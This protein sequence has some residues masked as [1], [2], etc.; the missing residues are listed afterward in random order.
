MPTLR[1]PEK[2]GLRESAEVGVGGRCGTA[3]Q[4][5]AAQAA[6]V[7]ALTLLRPYPP[8]LRGLRHYS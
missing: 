1:L 2:G 8:P 4:P 3:S 7:R 5:A 6:V